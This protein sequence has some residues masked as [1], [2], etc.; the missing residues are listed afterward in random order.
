MLGCEKPT[1]RGAVTGRESTEAAIPK[2]TVYHLPVPPERRPGP[3]DPN[4]LEYWVLISELSGIS[5][6]NGY[7]KDTSL[8][9]FGSTL[10]ESAVMWVNDS[11][12]EMIAEGGGFYRVSEW[13][14]PGKNLVWLDGHFDH[15]LYIK[16]VLLRSR[17]FYQNRSFKRIVA[18]MQVPR[19][20]GPAVAAPKKLTFD[21][22]I[23]YSPFMDPLP[24]EGSAKERMQAELR[25]HQQKWMAAVQRHDGESAAALD[26]APGSYVPIGAW[27][28]LHTTQTS[29]C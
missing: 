6:D 20:D 16:V 29:P 28:G 8:T 13:L 17:D 3:D 14:S 18:K 10:K 11:P 4:C 19:R 23:D 24:T 27:R 2:K 1:E 21:A 9:F 26:F 22:D 25:S 12:V 7:E 15:D 5:G